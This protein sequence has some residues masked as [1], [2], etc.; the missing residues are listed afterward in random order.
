M[1]RIIVRSIP[2]F[3]LTLLLLSCKALAADYE[4]YIV[5]VQ[6][7]ITLFS[8]TTDLPDGMEEVYAPEGL[9]TVDS[10][11][12][13]D[14]LAEAGMLVYVEPDYVITLEDIPE[15]TISWSNAMVGM[16]TVWSE[17]LADTE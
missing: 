7:D 4:G 2:L 6:S 5:R 1:R 16:D 8:E 9:Y 10:L 15:N 12:L 14:E 3:L 11:E 17:H 13:V